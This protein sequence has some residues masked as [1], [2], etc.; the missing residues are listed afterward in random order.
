[1]NL[2]VLASLGKVG[3]V[4]G[5]AL[6]VVAFLLKDVLANQVFQALPPAQAYQLLQI[7]TVGLFVLG[8]LGILAWVIGNRAPAPGVAKVHAEDGSA[9]FGD[10]ANSNT[11]II[12]NTS[13]PPKH[14]ARQ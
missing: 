2:K 14:N 3:G 6:G 9:A 8:A 1:M 5:I 11:V 4:G 10:K 12:N 13:A 7:I